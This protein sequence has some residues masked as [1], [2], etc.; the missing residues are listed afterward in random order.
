[1]TIRE[2]L[3]HALHS[4]KEDAAYAHKALMTGDTTPL[5]VV[6]QSWERVKVA[7]MKMEQ[8]GK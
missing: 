1:M 6:G 4:L 5:W 2:E 3:I 7:V 8:E